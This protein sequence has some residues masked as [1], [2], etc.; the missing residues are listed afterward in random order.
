MDSREGLSTKAFYYIRV[1][2][3]CA[4]NTNKFVPH[5]E[6]KENIFCTSL[7][8]VLVNALPPDSTALLSS[9]VPFKLFSA[10]CWWYPPPLCF[11]NSVCEWQLVLVGCNRPV[12]WQALAKTPV[13]KANLFLAPNLQGLN[14]VLGR[15]SSY[16]RFIKDEDSLAQL[17]IALTH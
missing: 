5:P 9:Y 8:N 2:K 13:Q 16:Q 17:L 10:A 14:E 12:I 4:S 11:V 7:D 6:G 1:K 3:R 15:S